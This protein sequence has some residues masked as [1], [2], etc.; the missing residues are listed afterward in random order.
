MLHSNELARAHIIYRQKYCKNYAEGALFVSCTIIHQYSEKSQLTELS[1]CSRVGDA[2]DIDHIPLGFD[3]GGCAK[4]DK[5][6]KCD[7]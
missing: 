4:M 3:V 6:C 1:T 5:P 7:M 2:L